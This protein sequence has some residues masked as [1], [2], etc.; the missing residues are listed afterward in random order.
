MFPA[1]LLKGVN[2]RYRSVA[3]GILISGKMT[4][5]KGVPCVFKLD[6]ELKDRRCKKNCTELFRQNNERFF[7]GLDLYLYMVKS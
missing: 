5:K 4:Q 7:P 3:G 2:L 1:E 6:F